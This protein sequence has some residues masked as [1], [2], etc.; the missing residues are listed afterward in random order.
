MKNLVKEVKRELA[1]IKTNSRER[2]TRP[3]GMPSRYKFHKDIQ[4]GLTHSE[5]RIAYLKGLIGK[6]NRVG[7]IIEN[8]VI[9]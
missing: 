9:M 8:G 6:K 4:Y 7:S 1:T 2:R 5:L 3:T